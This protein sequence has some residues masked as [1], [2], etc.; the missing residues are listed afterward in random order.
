MLVSMDACFHNK[1][2]PGTLMNN[3]MRIKNKVLACTTPVDELT[4]SFNVLK[5]FILVFPYHLAVATY[6]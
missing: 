5:D 4:C 6:Q 1:L 2:F 3:F